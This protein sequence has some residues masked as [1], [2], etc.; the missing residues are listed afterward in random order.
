MIHRHLDYDPH[1]PVTALGLAALDDLLDRGDLGDWTPLARAVAAE[2]DGD[3]A[4]AIEALCTSHAMYGTSSLWLRW[5]ATV[6]RAHAEVDQRPAVGLREL[7]ERAG[8]TQA[9]VARRM[10]LGQPDVSKLEQRGDVR[11]STLSDYVNATG[12]ELAVE[13]RG[14]DGTRVS[15]AIGRSAKYRRPR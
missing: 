8:L 6:R 4:R 14:P 13:A 12:S 15:L 9:A 5:I 3:L 7:R 11:L 1:T 2:P 10:R